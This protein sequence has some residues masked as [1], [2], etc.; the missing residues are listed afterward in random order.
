MPLTGKDRKEYD[1]NRSAE[2]NAERQQRFRDRKKRAALLEFM[3]EAGIQAK[4]KL[5]RTRIE[6]ARK[7]AEDQA[8]TF[9]KFKLNTGQELP[10]LVQH[11]QPDF[12]KSMEGAARHELENPKPEGKADSEKTQIMPQ[13]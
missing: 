4:P 13:V 5:A 9:W 6:N 11:L 2:K 1:A 10:L 7:W 12:V 3:T 8:K